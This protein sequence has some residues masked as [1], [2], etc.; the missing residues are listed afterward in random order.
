MRT[1]IVAGNW[2]MNLGN[3]EALELARAIAENAPTNGVKTIIA[4]VY[5][6]L[7]KISEALAAS[8]VLLGAQSMHWADSGAYTGEVAGPMLKDLA[9]RY[10]I[11]GH[12]ERRQYYGETDEDVNRKVQSALK[13]D[14]RP[15]ICLGESLEERESGRTEAKIEFQVR[16]A[17]SGLNA[18]E[19]RRVILA[20]E[21]LWAIGTGKSASP[22]QAQ[23]AHSALRDVLSARFD[24]E[25]SAEVPILYGGSVKPHNFTPLIEQPD[26]DGA[27]V[28]GASLKAESFLE[29]TRIAHSV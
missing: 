26:I 27:L 2:K 1:P 13:Q 20:Y 6:H 28:G 14:F 8:P 5:V 9:V 7:S 29:L 17:M 16:A 18:E 22:K 19:A 12:S 4:P 24:D 21:P 3:N 25:T 15:I 23:Q 11:L 10:V